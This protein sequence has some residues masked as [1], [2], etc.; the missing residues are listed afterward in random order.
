MGLSASLRQGQCHLV[1]HSCGKIT[2]WNQENQRA[3]K[4]DTEGQRPDPSEDDFDKY[5]LGLCLTKPK[6][7][8]R[9][10]NIIID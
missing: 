3:L 2:I 9:C 5:N 4:F 8:Q 7:K 10:Q 1:R 6:L